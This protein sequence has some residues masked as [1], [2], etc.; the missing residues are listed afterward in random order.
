MLAEHSAVSV[1]TIKRV[2][3]EE[4]IKKATEAN[5]QLIRT[6]FEAASI[7]FIGNATEGPGVRLWTK[8]QP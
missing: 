1:S 8:P 2:E 3:S 4:G 7:E 5:L 6:T